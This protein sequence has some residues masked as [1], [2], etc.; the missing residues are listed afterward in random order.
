MADR[1]YSVRDPSRL[2]FEFIVCFIICAKLR[3]ALNYSRKLHIIED[4]FSDQN[5]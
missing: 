2:E 5:V 4:R 1:N 3:H